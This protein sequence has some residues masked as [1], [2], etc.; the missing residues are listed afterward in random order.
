M[1]A[2]AKG[3]QS[4]YQLREIS[5]EAVYADI[6]DRAYLPVKLGRP[7]LQRE[8]LLKSLKEAMGETV[9]IKGEEFFLRFRGEL[10]FTLLAEGIRKLGLLYLLI[11]NGS[12]ASGSILFWDEPE[13][14]LSPSLFQPVIRILLQLQQMGV[15]VFLATHDYVILKELDLQTSSDDEVLYHSLYRQASEIRLDSTDHYLGVNDTAIFD[16][17]DGLYDRDIERELSIQS[18]ETNREQIGDYDTT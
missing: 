17:F 2:N 8:T 13:A 18:D 5:F 12:L 1:L 4:R 10:E 3:F 16:T 11:Q 9:V 15:Q 6:I 7:D 14:N